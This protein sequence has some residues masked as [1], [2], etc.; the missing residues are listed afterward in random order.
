VPPRPRSGQL[1]RAEDFTLSQNSRW[2]RARGPGPSIPPELGHNSR[3]DAIG[4]AQVFPA[5]PRMTEFTHPTGSISGTWTRASISSCAYPATR[6]LRRGTCGRDPRPRLVAAESRARSSSTRAAT[7]ELKK[8]F[9]AACYQRPGARFCQG[10]R[11]S[12]RAHPASLRLR[13]RA[14][15]RT[16]RG[17]S[18]EPPAGTANPRK[19]TREKT[20]SWP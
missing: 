4:G 16:S 11:N 18:S 6:G 17:R 14:I 13:Q 1:T 20:C 3:A 9:C 19:P 7:C 10:G 8:S 15:L 2:G 5:N 12:P